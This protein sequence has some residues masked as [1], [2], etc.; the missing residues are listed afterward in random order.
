MEYNLVLKLARGDDEEVV[1]PD[2]VVEIADGVFRGRKSLKKITIPEGCVKIGQ[3]VFRDCTALEEVVLPESA[4]AIGDYCFKNCT[5][6]KRIVLPPKTKRLSQEIFAGCSSLEV[7]DGSSEI[8]RVE[9]EAFCDCAALQS[10]SGQPVKYVGNRAFS[11][12]A[13]LERVDFGP[14]VTFIGEM[15][16]RNCRSMK[17]AELPAST[18]GLKDNAFADCPEFPIENEELV[19]RFPNAFPREIA[20][21]HGVLRPI[22]RNT[23]AK[24]FRESHAA[25]REELEQRRK[26]ISAQHALLQEKLPSYGVLDLKKRDAIVEQIEDIEAEIVEIDLLLAEIKSPSWETLLEEFV[27]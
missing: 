3:S 26:E 13:K 14:A 18:M 27:G 5:S 20:K 6:L 16:F 23:L 17:K 4:T 11:N 19:K 8:E 15:A 25:D 24:E 9:R 10:F 7:V 1:L 2:G 21:A 22:D 12:C